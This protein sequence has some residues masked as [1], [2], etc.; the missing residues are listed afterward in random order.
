MTKAYA[1][2]NSKGGKRHAL[3][4]RGSGFVVMVEKKNYERGH[5]V[6]RWFVCNLPK[7]SN[8]EFQVMAKT[9]MALEDAIAFF[10]KKVVRE[11]RIGVEQK[12]DGGRRIVKAA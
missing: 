1:Q 6:A 5:T 7:Q 11:D 3:V 2:G 4:R 10:N 9:G 12:P 8:Q